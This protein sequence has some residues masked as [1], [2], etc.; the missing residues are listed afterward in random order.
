MIQY[1]DIFNSILT[2]SDGFFKA[3]FWNILVQRNLYHYFGEFNFKNQAILSNNF[4]I[5]NSATL[6]HS[7]PIFENFV[8]K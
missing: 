6:A 2:R 4:I 1:Q 8:D 7:D 3:L 5:L